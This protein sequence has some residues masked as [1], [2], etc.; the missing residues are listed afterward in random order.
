MKL[1]NLK[2]PKETDRSQLW[3]WLRF[4][5]SEREVDLSMSSEKNNAVEK[6]VGVLKEL[7]ADERTRLLYEA[8]EKARRDEQARIEGAVER[9]VES[10]IEKK[11]LDITKNLLK[12]GTSIDKIVKG[13]GLSYEEVERLEKEIK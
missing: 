1:I 9:A 4:L 6:A 12:L 5:K 10:A 3:N 13:T 7:S 11:T 2:V 8:Q